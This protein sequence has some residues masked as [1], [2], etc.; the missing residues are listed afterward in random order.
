MIFYDFLFLF[1]LP[2]PIRADDALSF[3][4]LSAFPKQHTRDL[5]LPNNQS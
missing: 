1:L 2:K 4:S 3:V 5:S